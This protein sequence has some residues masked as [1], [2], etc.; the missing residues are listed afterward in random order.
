[1]TYERQGPKT[2]DDRR[3]SIL[4]DLLF[5]DFRH[6]YWLKNKTNN[7]EYMNITGAPCRVDYPMYLD[8]G[9]N[10]IG[11]LP[12]QP[13]SLFHAFSSL[14]DHFSF[15][16]GYERGSGIIEGPKTWNRRRPSFLNDLSILKP[17]HGYWVSMYQ[18]AVLIY[19]IKG[20]KGGGSF[21]KKHDGGREYQLK[22][23]A[24]D[25]ILDGSMVRGRRQRLPAQR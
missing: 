17:Q 4:N 9:W 6:G 21:S 25:E 3:P 11:Y 23:V 15:V 19:P 14:G 18:P 5:M 16:F 20:Y 10:L 2:W 13:D 8:A 1:M 12:A 7:L 24:F 22:W